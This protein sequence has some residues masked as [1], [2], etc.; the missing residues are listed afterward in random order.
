MQNAIILKEEF[1]G[2]SWHVVIGEGFGFEI[3]YEVTQETPLFLSPC[4]TPSL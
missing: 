2:A 4:E 1:C 3:S